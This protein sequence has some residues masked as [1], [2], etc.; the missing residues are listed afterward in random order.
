VTKLWTWLRARWK[1]TLVAFGALG[2]V[3]L[4]W[5]TRKPKLPWDD[6]PTPVDLPPPLTPQQ[7]ADLKAEIERKAE[8]ERA[9]LKAKMEAERKRALAAINRGG[10]P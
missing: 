7:G 5:R 8:T 1:G 4:F 9:R 2:G 6:D 3:L 10:K